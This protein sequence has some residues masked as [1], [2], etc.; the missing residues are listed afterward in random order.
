MYITSFHS[1]DECLSV[2][3]DSAYDYAE[4]SKF[5][6]YGDSTRGHTIRIQLMSSYLHPSTVPVDFF[7]Q[8]NS[9]DWKKHANVLYFKQSFLPR[10]VWACHSSLVV[11][12]LH[13][14]FG[15]F[16]VSSHWLKS[17][18]DS[19]FNFFLTHLPSSQGSL[20]SRDTTHG[21]VLLH[22]HGRGL[23]LLFLWS[24]SSAW[25]WST[26]FCLFPRRYGRCLRIPFVVFLPRSLRLTWFQWSGGGGGGE[27]TLQWQPSTFSSSCFYS[28]FW[29]TD[30]VVFCVSSSWRSFQDVLNL[31]QMLRVSSLLATSLLN[32]S[33][34]FV[35]PFPLLHIL[36]RKRQPL[37]SLKMSKR[38]RQ[39]NTSVSSFHVSTLLASPF[40]FSF[41]IRLLLMMPLD[42]S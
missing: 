38:H 6:T 36:V 37:G 30:A 16:S 39:K 40:A 24:R 11:F 7:R 29:L 20:D 35:L 22:T 17:P 27:L 26:L 14:L 21:C 28:S 18:P 34:L 13:L 41:S 15:L 9:W 8:T 32:C 19:S 2:N 42:A 5:G 1:G 12:A 23:L 31:L 3:K 10:F 4:T 33:C 25:T